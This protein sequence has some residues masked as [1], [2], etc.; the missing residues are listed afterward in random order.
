MRHAF[1][2]ARDNGESYEEF[3]KVGQGIGI[4]TR[5]GKIGAFDRTR[6]TKPA[7]KMV[8]RMMRTHGL[9]R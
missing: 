5:R 2:R 3:L 6:K 7:T 9:P 8:N 1:D 4:E